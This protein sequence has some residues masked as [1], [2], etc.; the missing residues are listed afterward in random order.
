[1]RSI[2]IIG[3]FSFLYFNAGIVYASK[4]VA[5]TKLELKKSNLDSIPNVVIDSIGNVGLGTMSPNEKLDV[6]G[7]ILFSGR[8]MPN[9]VPGDSGS[10][11]IS[12]GALH[13]PVWE[14]NYKP[15]VWNELSDKIV[16]SLKNVEINKT[17]INNGNHNLSPYTIYN[18]WRPNISTTPDVPSF[19]FTGGEFP[20]PLSSQPNN[21]A[22]N[23]GIN[24]SPGGGILE[25]SKPAVGQSFEYRFFIDNKPYTEYHIFA[26]D[27][28]SVQRRP[29]YTIFAHDGS[30]NDWSNFVSKLNLHDKDGTKQVYGIDTETEDWTYYGNGLRHIFRTP[31]YQPIWQN[32]NDGTGNVYPL[33]GYLGTVST[34]NQRLQLGNPEEP[35][36]VRMGSSLEFGNSNGLDYIGT[37][38]GDGGSDLTFGYPG[39]RFNTIEFNTSYGIVA[40]FKNTSNQNGWGLGLNVPGAFYLRDFSANTTPFYLSTNMPDNSF[41]MSAN[42]NLCLG[43]VDDAQK[44]SVNGSLKIEG[45]FLPN[46]EAGATGEVLVSQGP[47][48]P[49]I[50]ESRMSSRHEEAFIAIQGQ[51]EFVISISIEAPSGSKMPV[52]VYKGGIKLKY[53]PGTLGSRDFN[54]LNNTISLVPC[55]ENEEVEVVYFR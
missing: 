5:P 49:P 32:I 28:N 11:L 27:T 29:L 48:T 51:T 36:A 24:L 31:D 26:I 37:A 54:Y 44:L 43:C 3:L 9:G 6:K 10:V 4:S 2:N 22:Y 42:G 46:N 33:I 17:F 19:T 41:R 38:F 16:Y 8:L 21:Y 15:G 14:N 53:N 52:Q 1:M 55:E 7:N 12:K 20:N 25:N 39:K 34:N 35:I 18:L 23:F 40:T 13:S 45:P 30:R 47:H 50:W